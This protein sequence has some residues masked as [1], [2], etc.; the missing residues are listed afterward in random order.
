MVAKKRLCLLRDL[1]ELGIELR[2]VFFVGLKKQTNRLFAIVLSVSGT[3]H[4]ACVLLSF[5]S[6]LCGGRGGGGG[7][8]TRLY[9]QR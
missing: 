9:R 6:S 5:D 1:P 3:K 7:V 4:G 8:Y 2:F